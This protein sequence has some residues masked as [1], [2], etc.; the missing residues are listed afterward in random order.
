MLC[1]QFSQD[2]V[3]QLADNLASPDVPPSRQTTLDEQVRGRIQA[4]LSR[5]R[6]EEQAVRDEIERTLEKENLDKERSMANAEDGADGAGGVKSSVA[7]LG[8]VDEIRRKVDRFHSK[9]ELEDYATIRS[10][11]EE[12]STCYR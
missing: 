1:R 11:S 10:L 6:S 2:V 9:R 7:L 4:E 5:L 3:N 12:V 8:D